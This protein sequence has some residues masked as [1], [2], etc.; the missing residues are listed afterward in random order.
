MMIVRIIQNIN[1]DRK[2]EAENGQYEVFE[3]AYMHSF[4]HTFATRCIESGMQPKVLQK[5]LGHATLSVTKDLY[6]HVLDDA[7]HS[8]IAKLEKA[9]SERNKKRMEDS[10]EADIVLISRAA[11]GH[12]KVM[13]A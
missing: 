5:I 12:V 6:V 1:T 13:E 3:H 10:Q 9:R 2:V 4:R 7:G 11:P 8:E